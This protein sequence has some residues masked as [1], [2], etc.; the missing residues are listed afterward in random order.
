LNGRKYSGQFK[1]ILKSSLFTDCTASVPRKSVFSIV[2]AVRTSDFT[3][4]FW[5]DFKPFAVT[6][7]WDGNY[8]LLIVG[9]IPT[10]DSLWGTCVRMDKS[11][12]DHNGEFK[13]GFFV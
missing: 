3:N 12:T 5:F 9:L 11:I 2:T 8:V 1:F 13:W 6:T 4:L 7:T 10:S